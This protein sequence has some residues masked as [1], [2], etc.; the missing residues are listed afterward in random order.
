MHRFVR[1][2]SALALLFTACDVSTAPAPAEITSAIAVAGSTAIEFTDP[3]T[4][5]ATARDT[6]ADDKVIAAIDTATTSV[7][8]A[9][10]GFDHPGITQA[11]LRAHARGIRVR[12]VGFAD[13]LQTSDGMKAIQS[14]GVPMSLRQSSS[15]MHH[16]FM[17]VDG[18][19]VAFGSMN[20]TTYAANQND[21][22]LVFTTSA[23]LA[24]I[25]QGE[26][27]QMFAGKFGSKK[28]AR[29][30]RPEV[31]VDGG[32]IALH[33]SP[34]E[35]TSTRLREVIAT[36]DTRI[37]FLAYSFTLPEVAQDLIA[38]KNRGVEVVGVFDKS[39]ASSSYSMDDTLLAAG[40]PVY[41][42]GNEY[43]SGFAGGRLH[44]KVMIVDAGG[45]DPIVVTG[46]YNWSAGATNS[47][48]E[49][50]AILRGEALVAPYV[51][52]FCRVYKNSS[53]STSPVQAP[54]PSL[55]NPRPLVALTEVLANPEGID[56]DEEF[57]ELTNVGDAS[58]DLSGYTL[59]DALAVRH[60]FAAGT[61]LAPRHSLVVHSGPS[62]TAAR[63]VASTG[64]LSLNNDTDTIALRSAAGAIVDQVAYVGAISGESIHRTP[65]PLVDLGFDGKV[66]RGL[67]SRH[68]EL[69]P[70]GLL[71]SPGLRPDGTPWA[72]VEAGP[73]E[74][75]DPGT[76][77]HDVVIAAAL[78]NPVGTDRPEEWVLV[79]N[80]GPITVDLSGWALGDLASPYRH[81]FAAGTLLAPGA[82]LKVYDG[83]VH[84]DGLPATSGQLSLNNTAE[85]VTLIDAHALH[86]DALSW[87]TAAEGQVIT[88]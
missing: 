43:T 80:S 41:L 7:D 71:T 49:T 50:L 38:A 48:D 55:C 72:Q 9:V 64:Q 2:F 46:S 4:S 87:S 81:V 62:L 52:E 75:V 68:T 58:I 83:G 23:E 19:K 44:H 15:L 53:A 25:F 16:K 33:F 82:S 36:A 20:F 29:A 74:Q 34:K 73:V 26:F 61:H 1:A 78:P 57:V 85:T 11:V 51:G 84:A 66:D 76:S 12:F 24:S 35:D 88:R 77:E 3:G 65:E 18:V 59:S 63:L 6:L 17:I 10:F 32:S 31:A 60:V 70:A 21:E 22:N 28:V 5:A 86:V 69:S 56:R 14:A 40:V 30:T 8:I 79:T 39:S 13:E 54:I 47:N 45:Q 37:Y 27:D 42:D 67:W